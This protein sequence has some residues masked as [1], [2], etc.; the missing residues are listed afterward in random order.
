MKLLT[1]AFIVLLFVTACSS[2]PAPLPTEAAPNPASANCV[3]K[4]GKL[5]IR[6]EAN[7]EVGYCQFPDGSEC[8]EWAFFRNECQPKTP[9]ASSTTVPNLPNPA[10]ANCIKRGGELIIRTDAKGEAGYCQFPDG[11]EC[12]EWALFRNECAPGAAPAATPVVSNTV[13]AP[14]VSN[15]TSATPEPVAP[16]LANPASTNCLAMGGTLEIRKNELGGEVGYCKFA[17]GSECEEWALLRGEC[18]PGRVVVTPT[19]SIVLAEPRRIVFPEGGTSALEHGT[20]GP[21]QT[22]PYVVRALAG[23][24]MIVKLTPMPGE[25]AVLVISGADGAVLLSDQ[26]A[27][28]DWSGVL[29]ATQDYF[30]SARSAPNAWTDFWLEVSISPLPPAE[31][32]VTPIMFQPGTSRATVQGSLASNGVARYSLRA[33]MGQAMMVN[34]TMTQ[35]SATIQVLSADGAVV[36]P[37]TAGATSWSGLLPDTQDYVIEVR[38][39]TNIVTNYVLEITIP[40][41]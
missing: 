1:S 13:L 4:G 37:V 30:I 14:I 28:T 33:L 36:Q 34:L 5:D 19:P 11:S 3:E 29:P 10:S 22:F 7:G 39:V 16:G 2:A 31:T 41:L 25:R 35:G 38:S 17:D 21:G 12:E 23:Q 24:T 40:P 26:A 6:T 18:Q 9:V 27:A 8:E 32:P 15:A 20:A